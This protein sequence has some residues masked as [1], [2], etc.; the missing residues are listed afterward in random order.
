MIAARTFAG[1]VKGKEK[2]FT[3]GDPITN[4]EAKE[5]NLAD[6]PHLTMEEKDDGVETA[7]A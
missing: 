4:A 1:V 7:Q 2:T 6:K 5:M 3:K